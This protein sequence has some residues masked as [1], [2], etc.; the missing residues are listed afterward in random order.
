MNKAPNKAPQTTFHIRSGDEVIV[1]SGG[2]KGRRGKIT[3]VIRKIDEGDAIQDPDSYCYG[4]AR[5]VLLEALKQR[6]KEREALS[7]MPLSASVDEVQLEV[8]RNDEDAGGLR[9][10]HGGPVRQRLADQNV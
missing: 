1:I 3:R 7:Q 9:R 8:E 5:L 10:C 4:V 2:A 6:E